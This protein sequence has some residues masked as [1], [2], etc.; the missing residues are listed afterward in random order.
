MKK[1]Q[2]LVIALFAMTLAF[3]QPEKGNLLLGG[4]LNLDIGSSNVKVDG[5]KTNGPKTFNLGVT[6]RVG[7]F[8]SDKV[9]VGVNLGFM[10]TNSKDESTGTE[11]K[12]NGLAYGGGVFARY[13]ITPV[14]HFALFFEGG[15]GAMFGSS[16]I[17]TA[18]TTV[19]GPNTMALN[20]GVSPGISIYVSKRI[21]LEANYGF[22]GY[23]MNNSKTETAGIETTS[24]QGSF[25]LNLNPNTLMFGVSILF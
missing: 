10:M 1:V 4:A 17:E 6:P 12:S 24:S 5:V 22:I 25:G 18:G 19:D 16:K 9:L 8:L 14:E 15:V 3:A 11:V 2:V 21:A 13:Y 23:T 7:Y 20:A